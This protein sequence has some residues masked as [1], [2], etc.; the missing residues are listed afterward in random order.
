MSRVAVQVR[1]GPRLDVVIRLL[2]PRRVIEDSARV[3]LEGLRTSDRAC[4][5]ASGHDFRH[6][7][8]CAIHLPV[9]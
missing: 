6:H 7:V 1:V 4:D 9:F 2:V 3:I 5:R 8:S